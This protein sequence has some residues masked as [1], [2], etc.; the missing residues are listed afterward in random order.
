LPANTPA[1]DYLHTLL[2]QMPLVVFV[3]RGLDL[4]YLNPAV[5]QISGY[6]LDELQTDF[7]LHLLNAQGWERVF[8]RIQGCLE[9]GEPQHFE[10]AFKH[11]DGTERWAQITFSRLSI[12]DGT[13][14][15]AGTAEDIT[16]RKQA[17]AA[18]IETEARTAAI[19]NSMAAG[20][21]AVDCDLRLTAFNH[22]YAESTHRYTGGMP[23]VGQ[24]L[25]EMLPPA[26]YPFWRGH[27]L[28]AMKGESFV[29]DFRVERPDMQGDGE[30]YFS[31]LRTPDGQVNGVA[32]YTV[33]VTARKQ[34][35]RALVV[36]EARQRVL[37]DNIHDAIASLDQ[38]FRLITMNSTFR[39]RL[40][41]LYGIEPQ[42]GE[43]LP[44]PP[45]PPQM[46]EDWSRR[47]N[48]VLKGERVQFEERLESR[49]I[50]I[51]SDVTLTPIFGSN[52]QVE[53]LVINSRDV[54]ERKRAQAAQSEYTRRLE[55]LQELD[56]ELSQLRQLDSVLATAV[57]AAV[58]LTGADAGAIHLLEGEALRLVRAIGNFPQ[59]ELGAP[60]PLDRGI[61]GRVARQ[62]QAEMVL[63]VQKDP[64]YMAT[65]AATRAQ[66]TVPLLARESLIGVLNIQ[67]EEPRRFN[68]QTFDFA[69][70]FAGRVAAAIDNA[71]LYE[72][73]QKQVD[74]LQALYAQV[75]DLEQL[76]TQM[77]RITAHDLRNPLGLISGYVELLDMELREQLAERHLEFLEVLA[78]SANRIDQISRNILALERANSSRN[79]LITEP[80]DMTG[81]VQ[82]VATDY[83]ALAA[84]QQKTFS[85]EMPPSVIT[86]QADRVLLQEAISNLLGN[87]FKYTP[88]SGRIRLALRLAEPYLTLEVGDSGYGI[89]VDQQAGLFQPFYRAKTER[90]KS[91][92]GTGLGL[93]LVKTIAERHGGRVE[94][95]SAEGAGSTFRMI[96]PLSAPSQPDPD[97]IETA[98]AP[99]P[100]DQPR[101]RS[102][103]T[104][105]RRAK[106]G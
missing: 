92:K 1:P 12:P 16:P 97:G 87:A 76:K 2:D 104:K 3:L 89:P 21:H 86:L 5:E 68:E 93:S 35:E 44:M 72:A 83:Q 61:I 9:N 53:G 22:L 56:T 85:L 80:V 96:L 59:G 46:V 40:V 52:G 71:R 18:L 62:M 81:L 34:I 7:K 77:I 65:V 17:E 91:I 42:L 26:E 29:L 57:D 67:T 94:F 66:I 84:R 58:R 48:R 88:E 24:S 64:D 70:L 51:D 103:P 30:M 105:G 28:R 19:I 102:R 23:F 100:A 82:Q 8:E 69:R 15:L 49:G 95:E 13:T 10:Q 98:A 79:G 11:K 25:Q 106:Q 101:R 54:T 36:S 75:S 32:V 74:E 45:L 50:V 33:N 78:D 37:I 4:L 31:P 55:I 6:R 27:Y 41:A 20:I 47:L 99:G 60:C 73:Q 43:I 39:Q 90:T 63:N 38:D 14:L